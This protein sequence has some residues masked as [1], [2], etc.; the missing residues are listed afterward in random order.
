MAK[1]KLKPLELVT[2]NT[3]FTAEALKIHLVHRFYLMVYL[4]KRHFFDI[5]SLTLSAKLLLRLL[6]R[7]DLK[8]RHFLT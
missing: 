4:G 1:K 3:R 7:T 5:V 8:E 2:I 6:I